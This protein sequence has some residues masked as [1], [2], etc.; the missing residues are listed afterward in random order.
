MLGGPVA[1]FIFGLATEITLGRIYQKEVS[2]TESPA[3]EP[4][5]VTG[6]LAQGWREDALFAA[7]G[8]VIVCFIVYLLEDIRTASHHSDQ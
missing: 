7:I 4:T 8:F 2:V 6:Y 5:I 3:S 1:G